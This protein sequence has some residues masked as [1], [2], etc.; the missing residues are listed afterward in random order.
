MEQVFEF[1]GNH[2]LLS[3]GFV[4]VLLALVWAEVSRF[5]RGF[6]ELAPAQVVPLINAGKAVVVDISPAADFNQGHIVGAKNIAPSRFAKP[7]AEVEKLRGA[8]VVVVCK[9]GQTALPV[10]SSLVKLGAGEVTVLKGGMSQWRS[11]N[12][13]TTR[14]G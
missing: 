5:T 6:K 13:P 7:D 1:A 8:S 14:G 11:D 3:A 10:A 4:A 9:N 2:P 12:Y